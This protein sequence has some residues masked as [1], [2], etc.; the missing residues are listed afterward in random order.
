LQLLNEEWRT[1]CIQ[2]HEAAL[3]ML[4]NDP[5]NVHV[6]NLASHEILVEKGNAYVFCLGNCWQELLFSDLDVSSVAQS[7]IPLLLFV[8][9][10]DLLHASL[11]KSPHNF[12]RLVVVHQVIHLIIQIGS[13]FKLFGLLFFVVISLNACTAVRILQLLFHH[14]R[15]VLD[16]FLEYHL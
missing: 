7:P 6:D 13:L 3:L 12:F 4:T 14:A 1:L 11:L 10:L 8:V 5:L 9:G 15:F 16:S 2:S